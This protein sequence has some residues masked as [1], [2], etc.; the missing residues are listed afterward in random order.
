MSDLP[1]VAL[2]G[3]GAHA[4]IW[5]AL[6][7]NDDSKQWL[8]LD[9]PGCGLRRGE[10]L[11][12]F[13][14]TVD[15]LAAAAPPRCAVA[16]WSLGGQLAL[17]WAARHPRQV[18]CLVLIAAT[19][20]FVAAADWAQGMNAALFASFAADF[21]NE[22]RKTW[23]RFLRLQTQAD[24][25][26]RAAARTLEALLGEDLPG[27]APALAGML[28][29]LRDGDLREQAAGLTLP[30][31]LIH[32]AS[33]TVTPLAA[34]QWLAQSMPG[35]GLAVLDGAGHAPFVSDA[36]AVRRLIAEFLP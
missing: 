22:P 16:G 31:L 5:S 32:G 4:G 27:D 3:W 33:D 9:L 2:H 6:S 14:E 13:D 34:S 26:Q 8:A 18:E 19:P 21:A 28:D 20:R 10:P 36:G 24:A 7:K 17:A 35:A 25:Q 29:W 1:L 23:R 11:T 15:R 30:T 12:G